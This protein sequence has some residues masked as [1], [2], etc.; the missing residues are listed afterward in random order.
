M[1]VANPTCPTAI[2]LSDPLQTGQS[3]LNFTG[4]REACR[5]GS[6]S[7][8]TDCLLGLEAEQ[9]EENKEH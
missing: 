1:S 7:E 2:L 5:L 8:I 3:R 4:L 6:L 9:V